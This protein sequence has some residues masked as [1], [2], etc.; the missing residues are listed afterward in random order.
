[1]LTV[2]L[3]YSTDDQTAAHRIAADVS[4]H[5]EFVHVPV[6]KANEGPLLVE[7]L[8]ENDHPVVLLVS[9]A[10]L[11]NPN[12]LLNVHDLLSGPR[13]V[14]TVYVRGRRYDELTDEVIETNAKLDNQAEVMHYVN[15]WQD[16]YIDLR[17]QAEELAV[18]GGDA[19]KQY[20]RKIREVSTQVEETLHLLKDKWSLSEEQF[21]GNHYQQLFLFAER[22]RLWEEFREF[23]EEPVDLSGIPGL[24]ML[25]QAGRD[26]AP[27]VTAGDVQLEDEEKEQG[28][29]AGAKE[30]DN[31]QG[32]EEPEY[33]PDGIIEDLA[34]SVVSI[35][36]PEA[37]IVP[38]GGAE[39][40]TPVQPSKNLSPEQ[41]AVNWIERGWKLF[42][43]DEVEAGL[44]LLAAGRE[45]LPDH[46]ELHYQYILLLV[47][48]T[49][50]VGRARSELE[51]LLARYP[52]HA[53]ALYLAGELAEA[54]E[55]HQRARDYWE[56]L[57]DA[58]PFYPE[59]NYRLGVLIDDHFPDDALDAAAYLRRA[60]KDD[61]ATGEVFY[62]YGR[63]LGNVID[64]KKKAI[65]QLRR[66]V[67]LSPGLAEAHFELA[68]MLYDRGEFAAARNS[69]L[70]AVR[71]QPSYETTE[72]RTRF[73]EDTLS[74][75]PEAADSG[76]ETS[77]DHALLLQLQQKVGELEQEFSLS[78]SAAS[79]PTSEPAPAPRAGEGKTVLISG[80][81]SGI[82]LATARRLAHDGYRLIL[83][84]RRAERLEKLTAELTA[85]YGI[86]TLSLRLD[87]R[88]R[89]EV[90][91]AING[92]HKDW[93]SIDVLINN[94][95]KAKGFDP[96][97]E[98]S[99]EHWDEMIDVNLKG[100]LTLTR[101]VSPLM[102]ARG[103]GMIVNVASTAGKEVYPRGNVYC[104]TKH[105]VDALTYAMRLDLVEHGIRVGQICPAHVEET[106]FA[107]VR[108]DGDAERAKIYEDFQPLRSPD[109]AEAIYFMISQPPHV[110]ILDVVLQGTQQASSTVVDRSG[111]GKYRAEEE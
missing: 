58:E 80:A 83:L 43:Q 96:I 74:T 73:V 102:V 87:V 105:A 2:T 56:E 34:A 77:D 70:T 45:A 31:Q 71:L 67:E 11:T 101:E 36:G 72:L 111:R 16:R 41:Q 63:L 103:S 95:G 48:V 88:D 23:T 110:N 93:R 50:D 39:E 19:F 64:R 57:S 97:H 76:T 98:G 65:R 104:A 14:L 15:H 42:D 8:R 37:E 99:Y 40:G 51:D 59:L 24:E 17:T 91:T 90:R 75:E 68:R 69:Y 100:L 54:G 9:A 84:G 30:P 78:A 46:G 1:M 13:S 60:T 94:A 7:L 109:V 81:T 66:A 20:L 32:E 108:F 89:G 49:G 92:L 29:D 55:D 53:D 38:I 4:T 33:A 12:C 21:R 3:A 35:S 22:P 25:G 52:E 6:G 5:V 27:D 61:S 107:L 44:N 82:G 62:R 79:S 47:T 26:S 10:F 86:A 28:A 106:E 18:A 85:T